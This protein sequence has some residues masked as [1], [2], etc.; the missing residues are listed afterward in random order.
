MY[1]T[2]SLLRCWC[3]HRPLLSR[4]PDTQNGISPGSGDSKNEDNNF[5]DSDTTRGK[6]IDVRLDGRAIFQIYIFLHHFLPAE[7]RG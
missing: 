4:L 3:W 7:I 1:S 2:A 5:K 6:E